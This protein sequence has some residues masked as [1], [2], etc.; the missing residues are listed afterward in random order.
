MLK[1]NAILLAIAFTL[2]LTPASGVAQKW[3]PQQQEVWRT[4]EALWKAFGSGDV[5]GFYNLVSDDYR[6]WSNSMRFPVD[7]ATERKWSTRWHG[8]NKILM[9]ELFPLAIDLHGD[10]AVVFFSFKILRQD[11]DKEQTMRRGRWTDIYRKVDRRW[12][13]IADAGGATD[14]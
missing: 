1:R 9:Y 7:K 13:L 10:V 5:D 6:G 8:E 12:L 3:T 11:K 4:V 14:S 2:L